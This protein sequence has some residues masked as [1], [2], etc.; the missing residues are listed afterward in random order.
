MLGYCDLL[1]SRFRGN[2]EVSAGMTGWDVGM[3]P[4]FQDVVEAAGA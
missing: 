2:D 1:D 4:L 3:A